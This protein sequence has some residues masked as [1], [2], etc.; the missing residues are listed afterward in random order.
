MRTHSAHDERGTLRDYLQ[1]VRHRKWLILVVVVLV[2]LTAVLLSLRQ[3]HMYRATSQVLLGNQN[4][5]NALTG[6]QQSTGVSVPADRVAQTQADLARVPEVARRALKSV[7]LVDRQPADLIAHS[8]VTVNQNADLLKFSVNDH[9]RA[10]A[11]RLATAYAG[12]FVS[13]RQQLDA[14][15]IHRARAELQRRLEALPLKKGPLYQGL[16]EKDQQLATLE[17]LQTSNASVVENADKTE[18]VQPKPMRNGFLGLGLG[19]LLGLGLAFLWEAIDTRVRSSEEIADRL[20]LPLLARLPEPPKELRESF[21][22]A[23]L[24]DN[25]GMASEPFR[26]LRTNLDFANLGHG[27]KSILIT[28]AVQGEG[29]STTVS[30]LA[31]ALARKGRRVILVDLDLRRPT[32][33][34]F[35][36]LGGCPGVTDVA[37]G[38]HDLDSAIATISTAAPTENGRASG[39]GAAKVEAFLQV[40]P[41]G[42]PPPSPGDFLETPQLEEI[43]RTLYDRA[44]IVLIDSPPLLHLGDSVS[45]ASKVDGI[46]V[47]TRLD[48]MRR[49]MLTELHRLL[50]VTPARPL[51]FVV[52]GAEAD[53]G[54]GYGGGYYHAQEETVE[55][56]AGVTQ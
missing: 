40:L 2:P 22:L 7:G 47:V 33:S 11:R 52:T 30:N 56:Q 55:E 35:F 25:T 23:M 49:A 12:S 46:V 34:K 50:E 38:T 16:V 10:L 18:L 31:V 39:N 19:L 41:A 44:D 14:A 43:L 29:K 24:E 53:E 3:E 9:D 37:V 42:P 27:C 36:G 15:S 8:S 54:Y 48:V 51:G 6:T 5:A 32:L 4:L 13:Y 17:A 20:E 26:M 45:I 21:K 28:S 1:V